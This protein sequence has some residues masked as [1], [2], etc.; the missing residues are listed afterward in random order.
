MLRAVML[1]SRTRSSLSRIVSL[2]WTYNWS[3]ALLQSLIVSVLR[4]QFIF[5]TYFFFGHEF[6]SVKE[7]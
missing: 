3:T 1:R 2:F 6:L 4:E 7:A 5:K